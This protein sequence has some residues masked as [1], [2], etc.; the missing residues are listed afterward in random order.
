MCADKEIV[1]EMAGFVHRYFGGTIEQGMGI[2]EDRLR[3]SRWERQQRL[4]KKATDILQERGLHEPTRIIPQKFM[5]PLLDASVLEENDEL[6]DKWSILL[7]NSADDNCQIELKRNYITTLENLTL[8]EVRLF[9]DICAC[10]QAKKDLVEHFALNLSQYP[11]KYITS[12]EKP[13]KPLPNHI[14]SALN[15]LLRLGLLYNESMGGFPGW[16]RL[17]G[18]GKEFYTA[19][20][21]NT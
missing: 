9:D 15:N 2:I 4:F 17:S 14:E 1:K 20:N 21:K 3:F 19:C 12:P 8:F 16:V 6:Q 18:L 10:E 11:E 5:L 7:A 13:E